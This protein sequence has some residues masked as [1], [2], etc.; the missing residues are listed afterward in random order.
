MSTTIVPPTWASERQSTSCSPARRWPVTTVNAADIPRWVTGMP[1]AAGAATDDVM[2]GTTSNGTPAACRAS[3]S[4][5]P[6]PNTNGS[7]PLSRTT[8]LPWRPSSTS[9]AEIIS[10][11]IG[12][13]G[14]L[15]TSISSAVGATIASTPSPTRASWTTTSA[16]ASNRAA[17]TVSRSGSPGPAPTSDTVM[18]RS[19]RH[20]ERRGVRGGARSAPATR[21]RASLRPGRDT[22]R[23]TRSTDVV[24][25]EALEQ[26][27]QVGGELVERNVGAHALGEAIAAGRTAEVEVVGLL[28]A[29]DDADLGGV[30]PRAPVRAPGHVDPDRLTLV[31]GVGEQLLELVDHTSAGRAR[32]RPAP[33]RTSAAQGR[34]SPAVA[35]GSRRR[36]RRRRAGAAS[37]SSAS[38]S[39]TPH[40]SRSWR[41][42]TRTSATSPD[43]TTSRSA[44]R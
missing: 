14:R 22:S 39:F 27:S 20:Q 38:R 29:P 15:P 8:R 12:R 17:R 19:R 25:G 28:R 41:G 36:A 2:P 10:W 35:A 30:R 26:R 33:V 13:P 6:R 24:G 18:M 9:R 1:A 7:P 23:R 43:W 37:S 44:S 42:V 3:A 5:P 32:P 34:R 16:S 4:S 31:A 11:G 21:S 40:S